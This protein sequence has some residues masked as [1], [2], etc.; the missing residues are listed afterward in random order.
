MPDMVELHLAGWG[1]GS[2]VCP[3]LPSGLLV[4]EEVVV[5][6]LKKIQR[7]R[8]WRWEDIVFQSGFRRI[9]HLWVETEKTLIN[10]AKCP[11]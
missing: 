2:G 7:R 4:G 1:A 8:W 9:S 5:I 10:F 3:T 11:K 6:F